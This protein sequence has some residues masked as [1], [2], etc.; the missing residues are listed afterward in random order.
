MKETKVENKRNYANC[1]CG[2]NNS[3]FNFSTE[4]V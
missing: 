4:L 2:N 1:T 3:A